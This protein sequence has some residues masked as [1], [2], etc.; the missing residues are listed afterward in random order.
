MLAKSASVEDGAVA[1]TPRAPAAPS[2]RSEV[3]KRCAWCGGAIGAAGAYGLAAEGRYEF[4]ILWF[5]MA[6]IFVA[7][8]E[9]QLIRNPPP[10]NSER[11][12]S[13]RD[14]LRFVAFCLVFMAVLAAMRTLIGGT[15]WESV[16]P[17]ILIGGTS[18]ELMV[19]AVLLPAMRWVIHKRHLAWC[20]MA[21]S[22]MGASEVEGAEVENGSRTLNLE[23]D[24]N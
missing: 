17:V 1:R 8:A 19:P 23:H 6:V 9:I 22:A 3:G 12:I 7:A 11:T 14:D 16:V 18:W 10:S 13:R 20:D 24:R 21:D 5:C 4:V 2:D 15:S